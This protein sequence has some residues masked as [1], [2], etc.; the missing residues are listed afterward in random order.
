MA[1]N[2]RAIYGLLAAAAA[3]L[4]G[5]SYG[6]A[7]NPVCLFWTGIQALTGMVFIGLF[8]GIC[9]AAAVSAS[10]RQALYMG[11]NS[12]RVLV[13]WFQSPIKTTPKETRSRWA[14]LAGLRFVMAMV[15]V[16]AHL[17]YCW[18]SNDCPYIIE[19]A[20]RWAF[21]AVI[22]F[23]LISG[24]SIAASA[25]KEQEGF[26]LRRFWR[27]APVYFACFVLS[28][29]PYA[30]NRAGINL[31]SH[32]VETPSLLQAF[33]NAICLQSVI[34]PAIS[35]FAPS[36]SLNPEMTY[37]CFALRLLKLDTRVMFG[38]W[39]FSLGLYVYST[40]AG[41]YFHTQW[42][43]TAVYLAWAWL[44]GFIYHQ[45]R[46]RIAA[47]LLWIPAVVLYWYSPAYGNTVFAPLIP[48]IAITCTTRLLVPEQWVARL[49]YLGDLS[50]PLY[51]CHF[52]VMLLMWSVFGWATWWFGLINIAAAIGTAELIYQH[53]DKPLRPR[54][55]QAL[56]R[57]LNEGVGVSCSIDS[58]VVVGRVPTDSV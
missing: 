41:T 45:A 48:L 54:G 2:P 30:W 14:I 40:I 52:A 13:T 15:V 35:A 57:V 6:M 37:Y 42:F 5:L 36:W 22:G 9:A 51:L 56:N 44:G 3:V 18:A 31:P 10:V 12:L 32:F 53:I 28:L 16:L 11:F 26:A 27:I 8:A 24:Y 47:V 49:N 34:L 7:L 25:S 39:A 20:H 1:K 23:F 21:T 17:S 55:R 50:Y 4:S 33:L 19:V 38:I 46:T 43:A 58:R 29:V